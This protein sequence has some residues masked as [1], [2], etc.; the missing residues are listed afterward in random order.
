VIASTAIGVHCSREVQSLNMM[1]MQS[2]KQMISK[3]T[4]ALSEIDAV[5]SV[6]AARYDPVLLS[7]TSKTELAIC[8]DVLDR[9][10]RKLREDL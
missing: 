6:S 5:L 8:R 4:V 7:Q 9:T 2:R 3:L 1:G 10:I